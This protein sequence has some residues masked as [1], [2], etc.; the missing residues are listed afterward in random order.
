MDTTYFGRLF[1]VMLFK[2]AYS[3]ENLLKF[4]VKNETNL[5]YR[6]GIETL[7]NRG[8]TINAIVC[9]GRKGLLSMYPDIPT[10]MC[11]F[12]QAAIIRRY[13]TKKPKTEAAKELK[14]LVKLLS[15]TDKESFVGG[16]NDWHNTWD[17]FLKERSKNPK[18]NKTQYTHRKL[19]SAYN[20]LKNNLPWL[21][22]WYDFL[23]IAIPNTTNAIDGHFADMKTKLRCHNGL[24]I[25]HKQKFIDEF[26]KA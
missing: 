26:L 22:T 18:T 16:L 19:R 14:I 23:E 20:S 10:Q 24:S 7:L 13:L 11:Q 5:M 15:K 2:D 17:A 21:F 12:H 1:G 4:Y 3:G 6:V 8:Y 9:D 25:A